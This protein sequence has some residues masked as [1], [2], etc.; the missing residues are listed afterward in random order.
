MRTIERLL[1]KAK[2]YTQDGAGRSMGFICRN[3]GD[4]GDWRGRI[5]KLI[6]GKTAF[7]E[8][9]FETQENAIQWAEAQL[10]DGETLLIDNI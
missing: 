6:K 10:Q 8:R 7:I 4:G 5:T 9:T 3:Y 1:H 2:Q